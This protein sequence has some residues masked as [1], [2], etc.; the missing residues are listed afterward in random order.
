MATGERHAIARRDA[1]GGPVSTR[2][3]RSPMSSGLAGGGG[4]GA[5]PDGVRL[6]AAMLEDAPAIWRLVQDSGVL[7]VNSSYAYLLWCRHF[8]E[9]SIVAELEGRLAGFIA[10]F[11]PPQRPEVIFVWQVGVAEAARGR[12]LGKRLLKGLIELPGA[13]DCTHLETTVTP[14]NEASRAL[15]RAFARDVGAE[16]DVR[17]EFPEAMFPDEGHEAEDLFRIGPL[18]TRKPNH[19]ER[20]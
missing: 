15:F 2:G 12:G 20:E 6:R 16:C 5:S 11:R 7:D 9:T 14:S 8:G 4:S 19:G 13:R 3:D 17:P 10:G 18:P 1:T